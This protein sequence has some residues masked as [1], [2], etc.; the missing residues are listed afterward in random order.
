MVKNKKTNKVLFGIVSTALATSGLAGC[1][2]KNNSVVSDEK[3]YTTNYEEK[4]ELPKEDTIELVQPQE[5]EVELDHLQST[6]PNVDLEA[7][8][9]YL[10]ESGGSYDEEELLLFLDDLNQNGEPTIDNQYSNSFPWW[11]FLLVG[12]T[13]NTH[14]NGIKSNHNKP[15][16]KT[17]ITTNKSTTNKNTSNGTSKTSSGFGK[18]TNSGS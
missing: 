7:V 4:I 18:S 6:Y 1:T 14:A 5:V 3:L 9:D 17:N 15:I 16:A 8:E 11:A 10:E 12:S 13:T 2:S